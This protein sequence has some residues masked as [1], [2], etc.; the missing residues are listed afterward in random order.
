[1]GRQKFQY[2][3]LSQAVM[4]ASAIAR[5][6]RAKSRARDALERPIPVRDGVVVIENSNVGL[7]RCTTT[8]L[9]HPRRDHRQRA[10]RRSGEGGWTPLAGTVPAEDG[11]RVGRKASVTSPHVEK[12]QG[13]PTARRSDPST[14][15]NPRGFPGS[16]VRVCAEGRSWLPHMGRFPQRCAVA[17]WAGTTPGLDR[18]VD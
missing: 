6:T 7:R 14:R 2:F 1:M 9:S 15:S 16:R 5:L 18:E 10:R 3:L 8:D 13:R 11:L 12:A 17:S 4:S